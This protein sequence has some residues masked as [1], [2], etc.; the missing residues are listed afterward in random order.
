MCCNSCHSCNECQTLQSFCPTHRR[1]YW[2][3]RARI[4]KKRPNMTKVKNKCKRAHLAT[5]TCT[6]LRHLIAKCWLLHFS[7]W[8]YHVADGLSTVMMMQSENENENEN[9]TSNELLCFCFCI[10][11]NNNNNNN[12]N[13]V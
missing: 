13:N 2:N 9:A 1:S 7:W 10:S 8:L 6:Y 11:S 12:H 3:I 5:Y 4:K